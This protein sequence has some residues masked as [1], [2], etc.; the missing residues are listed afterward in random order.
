MNTGKILKFGSFD[1]KKIYGKLKSSPERNV[2][3][4][5]FDYILSCEKKAISY[6]N[7]KSCKLEPNMLII[8]KPGQ[9][10]KSVLH[11]KCYCLHLSLE[12]NSPLFNELYAIPEY[13]TLINDKTYQLLFESLFTHLIKHNT[14]ENDYFTSAKI[15]ELIYHLKKDSK[16]NRKM[17][18]TVF[19]KENR[20]IQKI[21]SYLKQNYQKEIT[22]KGLGKIAGYSPNHLQHI[23]TNV[24]GFSP[25]AY[26][27]K[28]RID[29]AKFLLS[30]SDT[31]LADIAYECGFSS[32]SYFSKIFKKNTFLTPYEFRQKSAFNYDDNL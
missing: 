30:Q 26:L 28:I 18:R 11:F 17:N 16:Q 25:Q 1:S 10:S 21:I 9:K 27:E 19:K 3:Y 13:Y 32:Q 8:R 2:I 6:I 20:S 22:L 14:P 23:F 31:P 5:E 29:H 24:M 4:F 7:E 15:L 12:P